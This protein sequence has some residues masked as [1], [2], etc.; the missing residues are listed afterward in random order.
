MSAIARALFSFILIGLSLIPV[1][2]AEAA[3][4]AIAFQAE[5]WVDNWFSLYINGKKVGEDQVPFAT[6]RSFN[7]SLIKFSTTYPFQIGVV[8]RDYIENDSGLEYIG[9]SNQQI[10]DAGIIIQVREVK[11]GRIVAASSSLW[12]TLVI[13]KAPLNEGCVKSSQPL[14]ECKSLT[15]K[16][17]TN[18][19][20]KTFNSQN[21]QSSKEFS[22]DEVGVKDGYFD[23]TWDSAAKLIWSSD[24]RIDNTVLFRRLVTAPTSLSVSKV[25]T[26]TL[27]SPDFI[28][29]GRLPI[30]YTCDGSS[31]PPSLE[32][33]GTP[34]GTKSLAL[35][36]N[37]VPGPTRP[38]EEENPNHAYFILF[39]I[40][41][42]K[43]SAKPGSYP[44]T[45]GMNFKE[46]IPGY[47]SPCSQGP[48]EKKYTFTLYA[49]SA[50]I[51]LQPLQASEVEVLKAIKDIQLGKAELNTYYARP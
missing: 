31:Q 14:V 35:I 25:S 20:Q 42:D 38:G 22:E 36:M 40:P 27:T 44:G 49:L 28:A 3:S 32:W 47:T 26:L 23:Y 46:K 11:S 6:E 16:A 17:P 24:L 7:S 5:V 21:W 50:M 29:N 1:Q 13:H 37:T 8:A 4:P 18:W 48:G 9:K 2:E 30:S 15:V 10:G 41:P 51:S 43:T 45:I 19:A 33:S 39:N 12:K 34:T